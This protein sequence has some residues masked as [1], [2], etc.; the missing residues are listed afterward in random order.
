MKIIVERETGN[1]KYALAD[2]EVINVTEHEIW[3]G[4]PPKWGIGDLGSKN[5]DL[6]EGVSDIPEDFIVDKYRWAGGKLA[7][8]P[9]FIDPA[10]IVEE[11]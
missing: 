7:P 1:I 4:D 6:V 9:A 11:G 10:S 2:A 8:N 3:I 5:S